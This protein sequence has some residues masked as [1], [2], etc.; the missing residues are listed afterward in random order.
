MT[1]DELKQ[2]GTVIHE[3]INEHTKITSEQIND[4]LER[5]SNSDDHRFVGVLKEKEKRKTEMWEKLKGNIIFYSLV[6]VVGGIGTA[7]WSYLKKAL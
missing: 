3:T 7:V 6:L 4:A 2:I 5:H 1:P